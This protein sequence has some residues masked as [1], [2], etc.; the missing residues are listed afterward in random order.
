MY[1]KYWNEDE[2]KYR[3]EVKEQRVDTLRAGGVTYYKTVYK[4]K[5]F[6]RCKWFVGWKSIYQNQWDDNEL[7]NEI[8]IHKCIRDCF[9]GNRPDKV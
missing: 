8:K 5:I 9:V 2:K 4:L 7:D 1:K 3:L 6:E